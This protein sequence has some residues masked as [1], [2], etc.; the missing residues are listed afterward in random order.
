LL[1]A[2]VSKP[3]V[4]SPIAPARTE[5]IDLRIDRCDR[6]CLARLLED[7]RFFSFLARY[8]TT[9][10]TPQLN[11]EYQRFS[12]LFNLRVP[13][14]TGNKIAI[15][16]PSDSIGRYALVVSNS[17]NAYLLSRGKPFEAR[18][19]D[20]TNEHYK[21][22]SRAIAEIESEGYNHVI[23]VLT[24]DGLQTLTTISTYLEIYI[25]TVNRS[26]AAV[27]NPAFFF[28]GIDYSA[29]LRELA[30][31]RASNNVVMFDE[32]LS[33]LSTRV[34]RLASTILFSRPISLSNSRINFTQLFKSE[35]VD[36]NST[37]LL[38]T[39]PVRTSLILSQLTFN[40]IQIP[41]ALSTQINFDPMLLTLT[42]NDDVQ[43]FFVASSIGESEASLR[44]VNALLHND[45]R[46]NW[47]AYASSALTALILQRQEGDYSAYIKSL[48]LNVIDNQIEYP[49]GV[50]MIR[51]SRFVSAP[52]PSE[53]EPFFIN[54][55]IVEE[56][57]EE[58]IV[59]ND[60]DELLSSDQY[61]RLL[62]L[63]E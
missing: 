28:G 40:D 8:K 56:E 31:Y 54:H 27:G 18:V 45:L 35:M 32:T 10:G 19:F 55:S 34:S 50:Y 24:I 63:D 22:L 16:I 48:N 2:A 42:Q 21:N 59:E 47:V 1:E 52:P 53:T 14:M 25:P 36:G 20:S 38:N 7:E 44:E 61:D 17:V 12:T 37:I 26:E 33:A 46:Y 29:Q 41:S 3:N 60:S 57:A 43:N 49:I 58:N 11:S 9:E 6:R 5:M 13:Q 23:A 62:L 51:N 30:K 4:L 15:L 39:P